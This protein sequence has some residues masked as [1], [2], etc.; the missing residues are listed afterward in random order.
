MKQSIRGLVGGLFVPAILLLAAGTYYGLV[1]APAE[2]HMPSRLSHLKLPVKRKNAAHA[3]AQVSESI[4]PHAVG[5]EV[6][7]SRFLPRWWVDV[8][9]TINFY[10]AILATLA[11]VIWHFYHVIF[12][13]DVYPVSGAWIDGKVTRHQYEEEHALAYEEWEREHYG[14]PTPNAVPPR[15]IRH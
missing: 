6:D 11:I 5:M 3:A 2:V 1:V 9:V 7:V 15:R 8:A 13:P 4:A 12:D 10:E 14:D